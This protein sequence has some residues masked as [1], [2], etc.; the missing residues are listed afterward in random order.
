MVE[1]KM[2]LQEFHFARMLR[3]RARQVNKV[4]SRTCVVRYSAL[5]PN[6]ESTREIVPRSYSFYK[7]V[8]GTE[9]R[10]TR[11][12]LLR[13]RKQKRDEHGASFQSS[14]NYRK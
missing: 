3:A 13:A 1:D 8:G 12:F 14:P 7:T 5:S 9:T 4:M 10:T 6:A 2:V 11:N